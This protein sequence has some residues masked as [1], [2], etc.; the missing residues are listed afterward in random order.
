[1][2]AADVVVFPDLTR[3]AGFPTVLDEC[4]G[5]GK[6]II[7]ETGPGQRMCPQE[8][9]V[10]ALLVPPRSGEG[11]AEAIPRLEGDRELGATLGSRA[12]NIAVETMS[13]PVVAAE[14]RRL[15][16]GIAGSR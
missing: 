9:N 15:L 11:L 6:A 4:I 10:S 14:Y 8:D 5:A 3:P 16:E 7:A 12:G 13:Y 2:H 1:M